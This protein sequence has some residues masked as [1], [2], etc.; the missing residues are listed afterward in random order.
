[1]KLFL[2]RLHTTHDVLQYSSEPKILHHALQPYTLYIANLWS[3][4]S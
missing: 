3:Y 1:M 2:E 4:E